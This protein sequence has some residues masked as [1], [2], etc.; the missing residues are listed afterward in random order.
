M[1]EGLET[2]GRDFRVYFAEKQNILGNDNMDMKVVRMNIDLAALNRE[3]L[4]IRDIIFKYGSPIICK[5]MYFDYIDR[6]KMVESA[7][8]AL[9]NFSLTHRL[10]FATY[11]GIIYVT[12]SE[13]HQTNIDAEFL[14]YILNLKWRR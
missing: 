3:H 14:D 7:V 9:A 10:M 13:N 12:E 2:C 4:T 11:T 6:D 8:T 1:D 5:T